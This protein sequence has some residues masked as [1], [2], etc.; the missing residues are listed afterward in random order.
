MV[1]K[2]VWKRLIKLQ[3]FLAQND[4]V[5]GVVIFQNG[6]DPADYVKRVGWKN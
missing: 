6:Q 2:L 4:F 1:I 3:F 5:G